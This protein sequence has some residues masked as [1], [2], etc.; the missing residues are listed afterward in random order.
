MKKLIAIQEWDNHI[1]HKHVYLED[2]IIVG[3][4]TVNVFKDNP[5]K[6]FESLWVKPELRRFGIAT[7]ILIDIV[8]MPMACMV[9]KDNDIAIRLYEKY[10]FDYWYDEDEDYM[11]M[12]NFI[13]DENNLSK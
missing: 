13:D 10:G 5:V 8:E 12:K 1:A 9:K 4:V 3:T 11:W 2:D 7:I 6:T